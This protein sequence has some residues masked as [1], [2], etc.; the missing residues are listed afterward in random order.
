MKVLEREKKDEQIYDLANE[1]V[2]KYPSD[3]SAYFLAA[4]ALGNLLIRRKI[5][6]PIDYDQIPCC[7]GENKFLDA[8]TVS[9]FFDYILIIRDKK[10][11]LHEDDIYRIYADSLN[12]FYFWVVGIN[13]LYL[14]CNMR[15]YIPFCSFG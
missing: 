2:E 9:D 5:N 14:D 1:V 13:F 6:D 7:N 3:E 8:N 12:H 11:I 15:Y 4:I 10:N